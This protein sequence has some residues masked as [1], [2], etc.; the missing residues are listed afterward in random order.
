MSSS[1]TELSQELPQV[2]PQEVIWGPHQLGEAFE[3]L[4]QSRKLPTEPATGQGASSDS[5]DS[6][7]QRPSG[8][9]LEEG[10]AA[11]GLEV[12]WDPL[13][14]SQL[15][16]SAPRL[17]HCLVELPGGGTGSQDEGSQ[18]NR[19]QSSSSQGF[20][21]IT[22]ASRSSMRILSP[23]GSIHRLPFTTFL[24][25]LR[26]PAEAE[27]ESEIDD[28][29]G[30]TGL[31]TKARQRARRRLLLER[32]A[33]HPCGRV[34]QVHPSPGASFLHQARA[35]GLPARLGLLATAFG[36]QVLLLILGWWLLGRGALSGTLGSGWLWA[37][38]LLL[39]TGLPLQAIAF[40]NQGVLALGFGALLRRRLLRGALMQDLEEPRQRGAG[41][42]LGR[43][44]EAGNVERLALNG[45]FR[46]LFFLF[47]W[48]LA[49]WVLSL[50]LGG[51]VLVSLLCLWTLL[52][53][54]LGHRYYRQ[55][56]R[57]IRA[58]IEMTDSMVE[59]MVGHSTRLAQQPWQRWHQGEDRE[60]AR[61]L[62]GSRRL[63]RSLQRFVLLTSR[64]WLVLAIATLILPLQQSA[65]PQ[66]SLMVQLAVSLGGILLAQRALGRLVE[67]GI[68]LAGALISWQQV[69]DL[70]R[71]AARRQ[72]AGDAGLRDSAA[73]SERILEAR[74]LSFRYP[75]RPDPVLEGVQVE[76]LQGDQ[77]LLEGP[78]G[79]GKSTLIA[80]L[81]SLRA[82]QQGLLLLHGVD[83]HGWG[84]LDWRRRV[85][86]TP[87]FHENHLFSGPLAFNLLLGHRWP[88]SPDDLARA[89]GVCR[90]LGLGPLLER[91][92]GG[93]MQTVGETG[94][95]L[96]HGE[97]SRVFIAR[98]LLQG[99]DLV[100]L[101]ESFAAMDPEN[102]AHCLQ[103]VRRLAPTLLVIAH[104]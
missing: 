82:P 59:S 63:D 75:G 2:L 52:S 7:E 42:L 18:G 25:H 64:G 102:L 92:P 45:G 41:Q 50:G 62:Q 104:P 54:G 60:L 90:E 66:G 11:L 19:S 4:I 86:I 103:A 35:A 88:P 61:Y 83:P 76:I 48:I 29:L 79:A 44:L 65:A 23:Q 74:Q 70:F 16:R 38:G 80:L 15:D 99:A 81:G 97:R 40:W 91:M 78:S 17:R 14:Y 85:A 30:A 28:L 9:R 46:G 32:L 47:E 100:V 1:R 96:S 56:Q 55:R 72:P 57:W 67:G 51:G 71:H 5:P 49:L 69:G 3:L 95:Q 43:V 12:Q 27:S 37:W 26:R 87:Q 33:E 58:R 98:A 89:E 101:D 34:L 36:S 94:W 53:L 20:L 22:R 8:Q 84:S 39:L 93:M 31:D 10:A 13:P 73:A 6:T 24:Q 77:I 21:L 68:D